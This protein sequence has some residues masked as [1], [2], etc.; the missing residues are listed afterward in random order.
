VPTLI[1]HSLLDD[2][3]PYGFRPGEGRRLVCGGRGGRAVASSLGP[4]HMG[5]AVV[6]FP[7]VFGWLEGRFAGLPAPSGCGRL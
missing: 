4:T 1:T 3:I 6:G 2:V 7:R 5:G